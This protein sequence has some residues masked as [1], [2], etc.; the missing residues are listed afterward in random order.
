[1]KLVSFRSIPLI[2][3]QASLMVNTIV[4]HQCYKS[5]FNGNVNGGKHKMK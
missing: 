1:M 4:L 5:N 2:H 3:F